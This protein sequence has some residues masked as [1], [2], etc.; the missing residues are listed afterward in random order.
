MTTF[1]SFLQF[2]RLAGIAFVAI[3]LVTLISIR[4]ARASEEGAVPFS[5]FTF[6][7]TDIETG[8]V[9]V[10]GTQAA[11][12]ISALNIKAF[13]REF[14]LSKVQ[15]ENLKGIIVNGVQM[16]AEGGYPQIGGKTIYL[17]LSMGFTSGTASG[18][19]VIVNERGDIR[20]EPIKNK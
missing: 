16:S 12:G 7:S 18:K 9:S 17:R 8:V 3:F 13:K 15:L 5:S 6:Q 1:K 19:F 2:R 4:N 20:F 14:N 11:T 10:S